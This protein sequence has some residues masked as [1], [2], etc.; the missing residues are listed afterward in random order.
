MDIDFENVKQIYTMGENDYE[1]LII[2][3]KTPMRIF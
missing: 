1:L 2:A 3:L